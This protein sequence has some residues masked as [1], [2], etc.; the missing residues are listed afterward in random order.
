MAEIFR[1]AH[2]G[3][4]PSAGSRLRLPRQSRSNS[5]IGLGD[6]RRKAAIDTN[7]DKTM[8]TKH[9]ETDSERSTGKSTG[10][11]GSVGAETPI[12]PTS[13]NLTSP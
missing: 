4:A 1:S 12:V 8:R 10:R 7:A 13:P 6:H 5:L 3:K 2:W 11:D 9:E